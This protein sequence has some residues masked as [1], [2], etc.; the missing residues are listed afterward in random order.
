MEFKLEK[1]I[2]LYF[3]FSLFDLSV[4]IVGTCVYAVY[5]GIDGPIWV[6]NQYYG[7]WLLLLIT[8][9]SIQSI[10]TELKCKSKL[11]HLFFIDLAYYVITVVL[12]LLQSIFF[13]IAHKT[14]A[15]I[16]SVYIC[17]VNLTNCYVLYL[18]TK[19]PKIQKTQEEQENENV[20]KSLLEE[21]K[22][23][24]EINSMA[25]FL[26][27]AGNILTKAIGLFL[28]CFLLSGSIVV[29]SGRLK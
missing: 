7:M 14:D 11:D 15:T 27:N 1:S 25:V 22:P 16:W 4:G 5:T 8:L 29:G 23:K 12:S 21:C 2:R 19:Q 6:R 20:N 28:L 9:T 18:K 3:Y 24:M 13:G 10:Y 26:I 17:A